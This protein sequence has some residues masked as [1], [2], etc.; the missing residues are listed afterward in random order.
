[1]SSEAHDAEAEATQA[2]KVNT[3]ALGTLVAVGLVSR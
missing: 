1:M 2:D 3:A